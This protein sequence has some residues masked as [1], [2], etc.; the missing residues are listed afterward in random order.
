MKRFHVALAAFL[1]LLII[2]PGAWGKEHPPGGLVA[3]SAGTGVYLVNPVTGATRGLEAGRVAWLFPAPGGLL[4]APDLTRGRTAVV[5]LR[6]QSLRGEL[7]GVTMPHFGEAP[8]RYITVAGKVLV[9]SWP[10]RARLGVVEAEIHDPWQ[11]IVLPGD[12]QI[13]ILER[14][15]DGRGGVRLWLVDLLEKRVVRK[16][17][18]DPRVRSMTLAPGL[19]MLALA[20]GEGGVRLLAGG[21]FQQVA[22]IPCGGSVEGVAAGGKW[23]KTLLT[24]AVATP[25][26]GR[27]VRFRLKEKKGELTWKEEKGLTLEA[28]PVALAS[29]PSHRWVAFALRTGRIGIAGLEAGDEVASATLPAA[30]RDLVWCDPGRRGPP[31][32][33]WSVNNDGS[34]S[35]T[36]APSL[37]PTPWHPR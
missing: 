9:L 23:G 16:L 24:V 15:H 7:D 27:L 10:G 14:R 8:D 6:N 3:A 26:G 35:N 2:V 37:H 25:E 13:L 32:P 19:G 12:L 22:V 5:D 29:S 31:L 17:E 28:A 18:L 21:S 20:G 36:P 11:V 33:H 4:F 30:P 34:Y 1:L